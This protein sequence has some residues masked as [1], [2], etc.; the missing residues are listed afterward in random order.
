MMGLLKRFQ[1]IFFFFYSY[2]STLN[3]LVKL[4]FK[5]HSILRVYRGRYDSK[6]QKIQAGKRRGWAWRRKAAGLQGD[7]EWWAGGVG[8]AGGESV[9]KQW[10]AASHG[11]ESW[12]FVLHGAT[13]LVNRSCF[14]D[15]YSSQEGGGWLW[16]AEWATFRCRSL[17]GVNNRQQEVLCVVGDECV[18]TFHPP[19]VKMARGRQR[20]GRVQPT[21][22]DNTDFYWKT[23]YSTVNFLLPDSGVGGEPPQMVSSRPSRLLGSLS[24]TQKSITAPEDIPTFSRN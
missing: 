11:K 17:C 10:L 3:C 23:K 2:K 16:S 7:S 5:P 20:G 8:G 21:D 22:T 12:V 24:V 14:P 15:S 18:V 4:S 13:W 6:T 19:H 9:K 1:A